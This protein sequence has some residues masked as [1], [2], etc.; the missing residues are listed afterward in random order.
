MENNQE[1][2]SHPNYEKIWII[3]LVLLV[4]SVLGPMIGIFWITLIT[5]FGI[6]VVK[7]YLVA[8]N[9]L[10]LKTEKKIANYLLLIGFLALIMFFV[11]LTTDIVKNEGTNWT[12]CMADKSCV[13]QR[14]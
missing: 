12:N 4:I 5:A 14:Y 10:H 6:A 11:S 9:F 13:Q 2:H 3:L 1:S 7:A 8:A